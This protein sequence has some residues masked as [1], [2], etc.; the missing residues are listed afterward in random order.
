[1]LP[2]RFSENWRS[3]ASLGSKFLLAVSGGVDSMVL[4]EL[5][6]RKGIAF[7]VAHCNFGLRG[8]SS[9]G[10]EHFVKQWC[11]ARGIPVFVEHFDTARI[12]ADWKKGIQET[13][14]ILRYGWFEQ[15]RKQEACCR[16]V[17]AHHADDNAET[18]LMNLFRGTGIAGIRGML[19]DSNHIIRPLLFA[20][21]EELAEFATCEGIAYRDDASNATDDYL[22]NDIRHN[23]LP[24]V[25]AVFPNV[26]DALAQDMER[27]RDVEWL[28]RKAVADEAKGLM[29]QRGQDRYIPIRKLAQHPVAQTLVFEILQPYGFAAAQVPDIMHLM[30]AESGKYV[31]SADYRILKDRDFLVLTTKDALTSDVALV[32]NGHTEVL[33][34]GRKFAIAEL[35][36]PAEIPNNAAIAVL[37]AA[38]LEFPLLLR[39]WRQGDYLYP[40]GMGMKK[41]KVGRMLIDAK[42]PLHQ[43]EKVVI[44]E[45]A[46]KIVWV[47]GMRIDERFKVKQSTRHAIIVTMVGEL[48]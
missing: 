39:K 42:M 4:A 30:V 48:P 18:L 29:E 46:G 21:K 5:M 11:A 9:N 14:R 27:F 13:A 22:R 32:E 23:I 17:T 19:P 36:M 28:Y 6:Y 33:F 45:S 38:K 7:I 26:V 24:A 10:D 25:Q 2:E 12:G 20:K 3:F 41:K 35:E 34:D 40:L 8:E 37:D 31:L 43:K 1:M 16:I 44:L 47:V 15:L